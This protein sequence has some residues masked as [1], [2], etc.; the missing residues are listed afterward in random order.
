MKRILL[1]TLL[2]TLAG[3]ANVTVKATFQYP[4]PA[5]AAK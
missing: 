2:A 4:A 1:L 3:C 5:V